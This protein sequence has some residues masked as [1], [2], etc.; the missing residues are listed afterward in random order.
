MPNCS[1]MLDMP[2]KMRKT[3]TLLWSISLKL[4]G[5]YFSRIQKISM[6]TL[7]L[8]NYIPILG[9]YY[10]N[11]FS[12]FSGFNLMISEHISMWVV[13]TTT[14][15]CFPKQK[16]HIVLLLP[17]S[18][19]SSQV[20]PNAGQFCAVWLGHSNLVSSYIYNHLMI[21][22]LSTLQVK[23]IPR[24]LRLIIWMFF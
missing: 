5:L 13:L 2:W 1:I 24:G 11:V 9:C 23:A 15:K 14:S 7:C 18:L 4:L 19:Q 6:C 3:M 21:W 12:V 8:T 17:Y 10:F 20:R 16:Q 22:H